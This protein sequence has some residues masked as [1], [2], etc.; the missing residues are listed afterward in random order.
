M[1]T[2]ALAPNTL[3]AVSLLER[4]RE[5]VL[6]LARHQR[7][8]RHDG[9]APGRGPRSSA[10]SS[11]WRRPIIVFLSAVQIRRAVELSVFPTLLLVAYIVPAVVEHR[12]QP[13]HSA[14]RL[15]RHGRGRQGDRSLRTVRGG[16]Q[17]RGRIRA[18]PGPDRH[19]VP[20][21]LARRGAH[22]RSDGPVHPRCAAGQADGHRRR[23]ECRADRRSRGPPPPP[24]DCP[25]SRI[26]RR[27][28]RRG[29]IQPARFA[30][31]HPDHRHQHRRRTADRH[32][33]AGNRPGRSGAHLHHPHRRRRAGD[34]DSVAAGLGGRRDHPDARQLG[35][36]AG[37][38]RSGSSCWRAP[39]RST[40]PAWLPAPCA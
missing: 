33:A 14:A 13:P 22:R 1:S 15:G 24:G 16:R 23:H 39:P 31:H 25:R 11:R 35:G 28:G 19:S 8:L 32:P 20:G 7:H 9:A 10:G 12:F 2:T 4:F 38:R 27:H 37:R 6:P 40:W 26:L 36:H 29:A 34:H 30:G 3:P 18:V 5:Y 17:L 21:G